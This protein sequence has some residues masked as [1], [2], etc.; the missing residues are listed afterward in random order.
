MN[1]TPILEVSNLTVRRDAPIIRKLNWIVHR[2]E[3]W[4]ILG[5]NGCGKTTLLSALNGYMTPSSGMISV[6]GATYGQTD[7]RNLR[8]QL[9]YVSNSLT[10]Q[11]EPDETA[12]EVVASGPDAIINTWT[13]PTAAEAKMARRLLGAWHCRALADRWWGVLSQGERQRVLIARALAAKPAILLLDEPC[14]GLD[15]V[16]RALMLRLIEKQAARKNGPALVLITHHVEEITPAFTHV[17]LMRKGRVVD[18]GPISK[19]L[20]RKN[21]SATFNADIQLSRRNGVWSLR[22]Q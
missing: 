1:V 4:V 6:L 18:A 20:N 2:G 22:V 8:P 21:L 10:R 9:G 14:A 12:A 5:A 17:M 19:T 7:W 3:H 13:I 11:I 16:A 15:P